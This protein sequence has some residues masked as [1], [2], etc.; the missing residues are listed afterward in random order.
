MVFLHAKEPV[1]K[2]CMLLEA[3]KAANEA[4]VPCVF[5]VAQS[6]IAGGVLLFS[7]TSQNLHRAKRNQARVWVCMQPCLAH[8]G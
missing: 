6:E 5:V 3:S 2:H 4:Y 1:N 7:R 8:N